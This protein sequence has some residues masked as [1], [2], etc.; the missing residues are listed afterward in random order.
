MTVLRGVTE[1]RTRNRV[2]LLLRPACTLVSLVVGAGVLVALPPAVAA[3]PD[4]SA[5]AAPRRWI[6]STQ[7]GS[8]GPAD[9]QLDEALAVLADALATNQCE[10]VGGP[11][12]STTTISCPLLQTPQQPD[13]AAQ[14]LHAPA[15]PAAV[16][17]VLGDAELQPTL[18]RVLAEWS[19]AGA[20]VAGITAAVADLPG[21]KLGQAS[22]RR[23][24][25]DPVAGGWGWDR[26]DLASALRHETG[27]AL[28]LG[29]SAAG[30]MAPVLLPGVR[31]VVPSSL[32]SE[33]PPMAGPLALTGGDEPATPP[34][35]S[36][37]DESSAEEPSAPAEPPSDPAPDPAPQPEPEP[38]PVVVDDPEPPTAPDPAPQPVELAS[39]VEPPA[40]PTE[41]TDPAT[42]PE[43]AAAAPVA[44]EPPAEQPAEVRGRWAVIGATAKLIVDEGDGAGV[45]F[46]D[47]ATDEIVF[48][49]AGVDNR[50]PADGIRRVL[51]KGGAADELTVDLRSFPRGGDRIEVEIDGR[52]NYV[53]VVSDQ[54]V[55]VSGSAPEAGDEATAQSL[56]VQSL[57]AILRIA[58]PQLV[59]RVEAL[60]AT[61]VITGH[62]DLSSTGAS[63]ELTAQR[64]LA[65]QATITTTGSVTLTALAS[66]PGMSEAL[67]ALRDATIVAE[68]I[69]LTA[70]AHGGTGASAVVT[71][72]GSRLTADGAVELAVDAS[73][74]AAGGGELTSVAVAQL[75]DSL[76]TTPGELSIS[77]R[78]TTS[79]TVRADGDVAASLTKLTSASI[80]GNTRV[81]AATVRLTAVST[82]SATVESTGRARV[83]VTSTTEAGL[84]PGASLTLNRG[85]LVASAVSRHATSAIGDELAVVLV[86]SRTRAAIGAGAALTG[87]N[88]VLLLADTTEA[89]TATSRIEAAVSS[90]VQTE[91]VVGPGAPLSLT[92]DLELV[93]VQ[94]AGATATGEGTLLV[95]ANHEVA[96]E[97]RRVVAAGGLLTATPEGISLSIPSVAD[98]AWV[99]WTAG[100]P[101]GVAAPAAPPVVEPLRPA[102]RSSLERTTTGDAPG[103]GLPA[104]VPQIQAVASGG[105]AAFGLAGGAVIAA[106]V[107]IDDLP[108]TAAVQPQ[109]TGEAFGPIVDYSGR[110]PPSAG[111]DSALSADLLHHRPGTRHTVSTTPAA[112]PGHALPGF[113]SPAL[114]V[115]TNAGL[116]TPQVAVVPATGAG[117]TP[118]NSMLPAPA[119][120]ADAAA[121]RR[122]SGA[123]ANV[124]STHPAVW[125]GPPGGLHLRVVARDA[126]TVPAGHAP[127]G[128]V[129][130]ACWSDRGAAATDGGVSGASLAAPQ[131]RTTYRG[132]RVGARHDTGVSSWDRSGVPRCSPR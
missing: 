74:N 16:G 88:D 81:T 69:T 23:I 12:D 38:E 97:I 3:T 104:G 25:V 2:R 114:A 44:P 24:L 8:S 98:R 108:L 129:R 117:T 63:L 119:A 109:P 11:L 128:T 20:D 49:F 72:V 95:L 10:S 124:L 89:S 102:G 29:H 87:A 14:P 17:R 40:Q 60:G 46:Y 83:A 101:V 5:Q 99:E 68:D 61:I 70:T 91:A 100:A 75:A 13:G 84:A 105:G 82:G 64:V 62:I 132:E 112:V 67:V 118:P 42:E 73:L 94:D 31:L 80:A 122:S 103:H 1:K 58:A 90:L 92:G 7:P 85:N 111:P 66:N 35:S 106:A 53:D 52:H 127:V 26:M 18:H 78:N 36:T 116:L 9:A 71:V 65:D 115:S 96:A 27:H 86:D 93:A 37:G 50:T 15:A 131:A 56:L 79:L 126:A 41:P 32:P 22:G 28:G 4:P 51:V 39:S 33:A 19:A 123:A 120:S 113:S 130:Q 121:A 77:A 59:A 48:R 54:D 125:G 55:E 57:L 30:L 34:E 76:V 43:P 107:A 45:L 47:A 21:S 110:G 6:A